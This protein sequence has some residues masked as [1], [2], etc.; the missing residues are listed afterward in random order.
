M[1]LLPNLPI[2]RGGAKIVTFALMTRVSSA[3][4]PFSLQD[5]IPIPA[6]RAAEPTDPIPSN[7]RQRATDD[8]RI[9]AARWAEIS[10]PEWLMR[11]D[12]TSHDSA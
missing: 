7:H 4:K 12:E 11:Y 6:T 3:R 2:N 1:P 10:L 5:V 9:I 8:Q